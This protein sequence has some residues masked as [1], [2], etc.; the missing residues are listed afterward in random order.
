FLIT[1]QIPPP[2]SNHPSIVVTFKQTYCTA[3]AY[4]A[5]VLVLGRVQKTTY[6]HNGNQ[7]NRIVTHYLSSPSHART[8]LYRSSTRHYAYN[9][10]IIIKY[11]NNDAQKTQNKRGS[12]RENPTT[13]TRPAACKASPQTRAVHAT[14]YVAGRG[15]LS[16]HKGA[17]TQES[18]AIYV[19]KRGKKIA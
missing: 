13:T 10:T 18:M 14:T 12:A 15:G 8:S 17:R 2:Q 4:P 19:A 16:L 11:L 5:V 6:R 1:L 7:L 9:C 3:V